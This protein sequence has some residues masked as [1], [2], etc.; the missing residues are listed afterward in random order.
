MDHPTHQQRSTW[1]DLVI[2]TDQSVRLGTLI[3]LL[4]SRARLDVASARTAAVLLWLLSCSSVLVGAQ[5]AKGASVSLL[6]KWPGTPLLLEAA[7]FVVR[8][9]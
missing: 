6:A 4:M 9:R 8:C 3:Y 1:L 7:E 2:V 5:K